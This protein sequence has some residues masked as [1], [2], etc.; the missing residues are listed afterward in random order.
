M[1]VRFF[2][3][4]LLAVSLVV[5]V[6]AATAAGHE[7]VGVQSYY[8]CQANLARAFLRSPNPGAG[9][10]DYPLVVVDAGGNPTGEDIMVMTIQNASSFDARVTSIGFDF[11]G[12]LGGYEFVQLHKSYNDLTTN[13]GGVRTGTA[14]PGDYT[15]LESVSIGQSHGDVRFSIREDIHGVPGFPHTGLDFALATGK[16][17]AGGRPGEGLAT[18]SIRHLV[19]VKGFLPADPDTGS[20][21]EIEGLLNSSYVR[22]RQVGPNGDDNETGIWRN[23]LPPISCP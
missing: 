17:F 2:I 12:D 23:L 18:D 16:T 22:F 13:A 8:T 15:E 10:V 3:Q 6:A 5:S 14:G 20:L 21:L 19:A 11:P 9:N 1:E 4:R 7:I